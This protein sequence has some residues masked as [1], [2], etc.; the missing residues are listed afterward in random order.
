MNHEIISYLE[1]IGMGQKL[2]GKVNSFYD[3]FNKINDE[4]IQDAVISEYVTEDGQRQYMHIYF[5]SE[6]HVFEVS[7]FLS[8]EFKM[9][10][11]KI[12]GN[13]AHLGFTCKEFDFVAPTPASR[14][15]FN[16]RWKNGTNF[17]LDISTTGDNCM[18]LLNMVRKYINPALD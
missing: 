17:V 11:S 15:N 3:Y 8:D 18:H 1:S 7:N 5:F 4:G 6:N 12:S 2:I 13:I 16:T 10:I 9:W 14:L